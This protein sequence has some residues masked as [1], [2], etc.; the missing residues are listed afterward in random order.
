MASERIERNQGVVRDSTG[1]VFSNWPLHF[2]GAGLFMRNDSQNN[3]VMQVHDSDDGTTWNLVLLS[4]HAL[5]GLANV[6]L[7]GLS[8]QV[9]L[10]TSARRYV[11]VSLTADNPQGVYY[12]LV[13]YPPKPREGAEEYA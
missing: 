1:D 9:V 5:A 4:T 3:C 8:Y 13:Q 10:F 7:V 12:S 2:A 6:T 11:R